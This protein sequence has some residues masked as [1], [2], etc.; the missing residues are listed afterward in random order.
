MDIQITVGVVVLA[1]VSF[2]AYRFAN[3]NL[4]DKIPSKEVSVRYFAATFL[5]IFCVL[6]VYIVF[7]IIGAVLWFMSYVVLESMTWLKGA[8]FFGLI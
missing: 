8:V 7:Y 5:L 3:R 4:F 6:F 1:L 2:A